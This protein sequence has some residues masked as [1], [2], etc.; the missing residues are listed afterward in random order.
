M[1][2]RLRKKKGLS[3]REFAAVLRE[4]FPK[5]NAAGISFAER[6]DESGITYTTEARQFIKDRFGVTKK[7]EHRKSSARISCWVTEAEKEIFRASKEKR[8]YCTDHDYFVF[9]INQDSEIIEKAA[10]SV[11]AEQGGK[12]KYINSIIAEKENLSNDK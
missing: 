11:G 3:C 7:P 9:L 12:E 2:S 8:G 10:R 4:E 5:A 1:F 6:P